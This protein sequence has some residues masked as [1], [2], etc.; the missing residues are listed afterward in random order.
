MECSDERLFPGIFLGSWALSGPVVWAAVS[1]F[2]DVG[3]CWEP[4]QP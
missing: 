3:H 4:Y 2:L 1:R